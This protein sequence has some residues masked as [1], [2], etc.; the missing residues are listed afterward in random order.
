MC[1]VFIHTKNGVSASWAALDEVLAA[2][3]VSSSMVS[4]RFF[5]RAPVSSM[6][7][8]PT[9]PYRPCSVSSSSSVAHEWMTPRGRAISLNRGNSSGDGQF[10]RSGSSSALRW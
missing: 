9:R 3:I 4:I 5:V 8:F 7:C 10:G 1:V 2:A 6:R